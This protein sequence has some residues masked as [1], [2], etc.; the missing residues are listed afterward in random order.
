MF[1]N[2][3][4]IL[5]K[6]GRS[7]KIDFGGI[8]PKNVFQ[9]APYNAV[10][11]SIH[12][13]L[14]EV[15]IAEHLNSAV[16]S[17]IFGVETEETSNTA[18]NDAFV[19]ITKQADSASTGRLLLQHVDSAGV[20]TQLPLRFFIDRFN[21][22]LSKPYAY[23]ATNTLSSSE[24]TPQYLVI[25]VN[26]Y[27]SSNVL[28]KL[29][30][31]EFVFKPD[32]IFQDSIT[33]ES[34]DEVTKDTLVYPF[35][36]RVC[37]GKNKTV[38]DLYT[39]LTSFKIAD[40]TVFTVQKKFNSTDTFYD[41]VLLTTLL[42]LDSTINENKILN[43]I[44]PPRQIVLTNTLLDTLFNS[45]EFNALSYTISSSGDMVFDN[46]GVYGAMF[47]FSDLAAGNPLAPSEMSLF[48]NS[49]LMF[50][51]NSKNDRHLV[52][53][54][55]I[56]DWFSSSNPSIATNGHSSTLDFS[57]KI[58]IP[59]FGINSNSFYIGSCVFNNSELISTNKLNLS[60]P[61]QY[62]KPLKESLI[63]YDAS[64][65]PAPHIDFIEDIYRAI[66]R[67]FTVPTNGKYPSDLSDSSNSLV[68]LA[69]L[70]AGQNLVNP[71]TIII[72]PMLTSNRPAINAYQSILEAY[73][74]G[75]IK[76]GTTIIHL[77][78]EFLSEYDSQRNKERSLPA[79]GLPKGVA[80]IAISP[81][82]TTEVSG[83]TYAPAYGDAEFSFENAKLGS[84][85][86]TQGLNHLDNMSK[87]Q[88]FICQ[89]TV[90]G[91]YGAGDE[92]TVSGIT[93]ENFQVFLADNISRSSIS[94]YMA[95]TVVTFNDCD[96]S[97]LSGPG[98]GSFLIPAEITEGIYPT[99]AGVIIN[100]ASSRSRTITKFL[101]H[102]A[103][104]ELTI[105]N[106]TYKL[107][108]IVIARLNRS[109]VKICNICSAIFIQE[110]TADSTSY[111]V[112]LS[113]LPIPLAAFTNKSL[114]AKFLR[115][116]SL[117]YT[118]VSGGTHSLSISFSSA[119]GTAADKDTRALSSITSLI[120]TYSLRGLQEE[121][122]NSNCNFTV[123]IT[124]TPYSY[125]P[126]DG[127][128]LAWTNFEKNIFLKSDTEE[129]NNNFLFFDCGA[130]N[131]AVRPRG[132]LE[133][134]ALTID[135]TDAV[136]D[137]N[138]VIFFKSGL[139]R[140][141]AYI[142]Y[143]SDKH[144]GI[145]IGSRELSSVDIN[146]KLPKT[147]AFDILNMQ[148][149]HLLTL[150][151]TTN[152]LY[153]FS[154]EVKISFKQLA[155]FSE[156]SYQQELGIVTATPCMPYSTAQTTSFNYLSKVLC[157][158]IKQGTFNCPALQVP[159]M[160]YV[161]STL[162][163]TTKMSETN[164]LG[165]GQN[166]G[167]VLFEDTSNFKV[168]ISSLDTLFILP[169]WNYNSNLILSETYGGFKFASVSNPVESVNSNLDI[170]V[171]LWAN[172]SSF[173]G[174]LFCTN[175]KLTASYLFC[176]QFKTLKNYSREDIGAIKTKNTSYAMHTTEISSNML[177]S[178]LPV[179]PV[180]IGSGLH[181]TE[182]QLTAHELHAAAK[183]IPATATISFDKAIYT[184][185]L[186]STDYFPSFCKG[187]DIDATLLRWNGPNDK[188]RYM[189]LLLGVDLVVVENV[190][191]ERDFKL[192]KFGAPINGCSI[193]GVYTRINKTTG[194]NNH[195]IGTV[196]TVGKPKASEIQASSAWGKGVT[197]QGRESRLYFTDLSYN[198]SFNAP[199]LV[200]E[201]GL[202]F[203]LAS[204]DPFYS[205]LTVSGDI[206][207]YPAKTESFSGSASSPYGSNAYTTG[208][209]GAA[210]A[211]SAF[212]Y[213]NDS[214]I[215]N[216][217]D[218][219]MLKAVIVNP[220]ILTNGEAINIGL[221]DYILT[222]TV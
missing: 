70:I 106:D 170:S 146:I 203:T 113:H 74:D 7:V 66:S 91:I 18:I 159:P 71:Q 93:A 222:R 148:N 132:T 55:T 57:D 199:D 124:D 12:T 196:F 14:K 133:N 19:K 45:T 161:D 219:V 32:L 69:E 129:L 178:A 160:A 112:T 24:H 68:K 182:L 51:P 23:I 75:K 65:L 16:T 20:P 87:N 152:P 167:T 174:I 54:A 107:P 187:G 212:E 36:F 27:A 38:A 15:F 125:S 11:S 135:L 34:I 180:F 173:S 179:L 169:E 59:L 150:P 62:K 60:I 143:F 40:T 47:K 158:G 134:V 172:R 130:F 198:E 101:T 80:H 48:E 99:W 123:K 119:Y 77:T 85:F 197:W 189:R 145:P 156:F 21:T 163:R 126:I 28:S 83:I 221:L 56:P 118:G 168:S 9:S 155:I 63:Q 157:S 211:N 4:D 8:T 81:N 64:A 94:D 191:T 121:L 190:G 22:S 151:D 84:L 6:L 192:K 207:S 79:E 10:I 154:P 144:P 25:S 127:V 67:F 86:I 37:F 214:F 78:A 204:Y 90:Y 49:A 136:S 216:A 5:K 92:L 46:P 213:L 110:G 162:N 188:L 96:I 128:E 142:F 220:G 175:S 89:E 109:Q 44:Y 100:G 97:L 73:T 39:A 141:S 139:F 193:R 103:A 171:G 105:D 52:T 117:I 200:T 98:R 165:Y 13:A 215:Y 194:F 176:S 147:T 131:E 88:T 82:C 104:Y 111:E 138:S 206:A 217:T 41:S 210:V 137:T 26:Y 181:G 218:L 95:K 208:N 42:K 122:T 116:N 185:K 2:I 3:P 35:G 140:K 201:G 53:T 120:A 166:N 195:I 43:F 17:G 102:T 61:G 50:I 209:T 29:T 184:R 108:R 183:E 177:I 33:V 76:P 202:N 30:Y 153:D 164:F 31:I 149:S 186:T 1:S 114:F 58:F 205:L 115:G 72:D